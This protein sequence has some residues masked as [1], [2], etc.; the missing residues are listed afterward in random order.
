MKR[1]NN[2]HIYKSEYGYLVKIAGELF[3]MSAN[4]LSPQGVNTYMGPASEYRVAKHEI[5][6]KDTPPE[7][8]QGIAKRLADMRG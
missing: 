2:V 1:T 3:E 7:V 6:V 4:C 5:A 8:L